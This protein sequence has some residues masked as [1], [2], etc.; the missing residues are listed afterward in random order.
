MPKSANKTVLC[1]SQ[2]CSNGGRRLDAGALTSVGGTA[3]ITDS[4]TGTGTD[5]G[6]VLFTPS[7]ACRSIGPHHNHAVVNGCQ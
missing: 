3:L 5:T 4:G 2:Y 7:P 6:N 1:G